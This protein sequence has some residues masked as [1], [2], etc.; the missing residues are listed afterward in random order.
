CLQAHYRS[1]LEF[2]WEGLGAAL[3]R[4][5]RMLMAVERLADAASGDPSHP[6]LAP[7]LEKFDAA[8]SDDLNTPVALT[9]LEEAVTVKK[10]DPAAKR[11]LVERMDAV[12]GLGLFTLSRL[13]LRIR[14]KAAS[15]DEE[16]IES[17]LARRKEARAEKN[18]AESDAIRDELAGKGVEVMDG[19]PLG[20]EWKPAP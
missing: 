12:L 9:V 14:P 13:E 4:L 18:F 8:I 5:K 20:W 17:A 7:L 6:K 10:V 19:D 3:T 16:E 1:E 2:S 11:A 15:I